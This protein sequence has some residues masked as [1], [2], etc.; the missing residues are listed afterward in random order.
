MLN[1]IAC[2]GL[3]NELG[4]DNKLIF[5]YK[6]DMKFFKS[7]T[8]GMKIV[9]GRKTFESL[10]KMLPHRQHIVITKNKD[11]NVDGVE[12]FNS[13]EDFLNEYKNKDNEIFVIGGGQIYSSLLKYCDYMYLTVVNQYAE[14]DTY[15]PRYEKYFK[16]E[17]II[18]ECKDFKI[19]KFKRRTNE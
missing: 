2:I 15:F 16:Q 12:V 13:I 18:Y 7:K 19:V 9:M 4:K 3:G 11:F 1:I 17:E 5:H 6:E 10:P 14:A 8:A